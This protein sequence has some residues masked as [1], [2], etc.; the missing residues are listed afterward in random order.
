MTPSPPTHRS[1]QHSISSYSP[2]LTQ[3]R[4]RHRSTQAHG[5]ARAKVPMAPEVEPWDPW[6]DGEDW[7]EK[8]GEEDWTG[9][10]IG[11]ARAG[12]EVWGTT[13]STGALEV[14]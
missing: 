5:A 6:A 9:R 3:A 11:A 1:S 7:A 12:V 4:K 13:G 10:R 8:V 2:P 14:L